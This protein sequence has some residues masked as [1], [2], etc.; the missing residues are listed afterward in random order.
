MPSSS[1]AR[2]EPPAAAAG[3]LEHVACNLCGEDAPRRLFEKHGYTIVRCR[4]CGLGY[5]DPRP[6]RPELVQI[7]RGEAYY[8]NKNEQAFG[9]GDYLRDRVLLEP[10]FGERMAAIERRRPARGRLLDVGCAT[11]VLLAEARRRGWE[12]RGC[13]VSDFAVDYCRQRGFEV[14][15]GEVRSAHFPTGSFDVV[16]TDD[17]VEHMPDPRA[18][19]RE[20]HRILAPGGLLTVNTANEGGWLRFLMGRQWFHYK[21]MEHLYYFSPRTLGRLLEE[22]GFHVLRH[23]LSGKIVTFRYLC[24]RARTY[25]PL[26]SRALLATVARTRLAQRPFFLPIGEFVVFAEKP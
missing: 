9:Y 3:A 16:V 25:S 4:R 26:L 1:A 14:H 15:H 11:G 24:A 5:V 23:E 21:P 6:R 13:D 8:R 7:Y 17:T 18:E 2:P 22:C 19:I 10:L 20:M 12:V